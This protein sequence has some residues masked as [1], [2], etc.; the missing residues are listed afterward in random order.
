MFNSVHTNE[1]TSH[2]NDGHIEP[3]LADPIAQT[4][5]IDSLSAHSTPVQLPSVEPPS[6]QS[7]P[8]QLPPVEPSSVRSSPGR[9]PNVLDPSTGLESSAELLQG[10]HIELSSI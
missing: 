3:N 1:G 2:S 5:P 7:P 10:D 4:P 6:V 9:S 8:I